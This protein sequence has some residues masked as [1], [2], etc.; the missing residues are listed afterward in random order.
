[1]E[2]TPNPE[3]NDT[4]CS[5]FQDV[6]RIPSPASCHRASTVAATSASSY[7]LSIIS[8][9]RQPHCSRAAQCPYSRARVAVRL[10]AHSQSFHRLAFAAAQKGN[11]MGVYANDKVGS[12]IWELH[13]FSTHKPTRATHW[14][15]GQVGCWVM[16]WRSLGRGVVGGQ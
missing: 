2:S 16:V 1:M 5:L 11:A 8:L 6:P 10:L 4:L 9:D 13:H 7:V 15:R 3:S 14:P 12:P